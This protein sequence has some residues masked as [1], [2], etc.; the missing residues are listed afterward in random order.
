MKSNSHLT[1][2]LV[3][4]VLA[5]ATLAISPIRASATTS[6]YNIQTRIPD[7]RTGKYLCLD[8][9]A[10]HAGAGAA[11]NVVNCSSTNY[12][13]WQLIADNGYP[14]MVN[15]GHSGYCLAVSTL[16]A[17]KAMELKSC[18][19]SDHTVNWH[20]DIANNYNGAIYNWWVQ[21]LVLDAINL[22]N[23]YGVYLENYAGGASSQAWR[24]IRLS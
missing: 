5:V 8:A 19:G 10:N 20:G 11:V 23:G 2:A 7:S 12:Q 22:H 4:A 13:K 9:D 21:S 16:T 3:V 6:V 17:N 24:L 15:I 18:S 14:V 1:R